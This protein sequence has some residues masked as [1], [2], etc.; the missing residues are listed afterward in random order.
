MLI[1]ISYYEK[2]NPEIIS[3]FKNI[4]NKKVNS[5]KTKTVASI[6]SF[7][8]LHVIFI[9]YKSLYHDFISHWMFNLIFTCID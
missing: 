4:P 7:K 6:S 9:I 5:L 2:L 8:V 1:S 3:F